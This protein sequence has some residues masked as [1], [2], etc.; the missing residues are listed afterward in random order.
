MCH[1]LRQ[2]TSNI[3]LSDL[4]PSPP[5]PPPSPPAP[6]A[7]QLYCVNCQHLSSQAMAAMTRGVNDIRAQSE[8]ACVTNAT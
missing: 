5:S 3:A 1:Q 8:R 7:E 6:A 2:P 4:A